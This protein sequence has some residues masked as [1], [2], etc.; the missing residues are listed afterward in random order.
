MSCFR[1]IAAFKL[2]GGGVSFVERARHDIVGDVKLP[3]GQ[4]QGCRVDRAR[5]W[6]LR[7]MHEAT[8]HE[9]ACFLTLTYA[10]EHL[11]PGGSLNYRDFQQFMYRYRR[12]VGS[13]IRFFMCG[14]YGEQLQ[15][16]H[17]HAIIFGHQFSDLVPFGRGE[18]GELSYTSQ[19]LSQ[20]W[21]KG[22][23]LVGTLT[24]ASAGYVARYNLK[25]VTGDLAKEYYQ[26]VDSDGVIHPVTP[27]FCRMS[28]RPGI[29]AK[30]YDKFHSDVHVHD[31]VVH[32]GVRNRIPRYYDKRGRDR[33]DIEQSKQ[34]R[35]LKAVKHAANNT[36]E[37]LLVR[38]EVLKASMK[39]LKRSI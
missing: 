29:G 27:E 9:S 36:P 17:Y 26:T 28:T 7:I 3:C 35:T 37:R 32:D 23:C 34:D 25:K 11:P 4:C 13:G 16:P 10:P 38:E 33:Y 24:K 22:H 18:S 6:S 12:K 5:D 39:S 19:T 1:P 20:L 14:E 8:L 15:R 21:K 2:A 30:W 31:Y